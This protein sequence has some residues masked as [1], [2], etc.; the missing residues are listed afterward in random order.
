MLLRKSFAAY[1]RHAWAMVSVNLA[2]QSVH[3]LPST[4]HEPHSALLK[5]VNNVRDG[6]CFS[7]NKTHLNRTK[8]PRI[9]I[10]IHCCWK[11]KALIQ[12]LEF[13]VYKRPNN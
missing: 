13:Y 1:Y 7:K 5:A 11:K 3:H 12:Y 4:T 8:I 6:C 10:R 9:Q 2:T